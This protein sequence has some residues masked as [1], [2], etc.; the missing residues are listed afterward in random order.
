MPIA[1]GYLA[2]AFTLGITAKNAGMTA[3]Q[4]TITSLAC[5]ASAGQ[6]AG[7][8]VI[9]AGGTY[10]EMA[11]MELVAN[12]RYLLMSCSLSQKFS[13]KT[14]LIHRLAVG[15][16]VTDEIFGVAVSEPGFLNPFYNYGMITVAVPGWALGTFLGV[17]L[18]NILPAPV[19]SAL[20][21]GLYGMFIAIIIPPAK[22]SRILTVLITISMAASFLFSKLPATATISP[23]IRTI[24]LTVVIAGIAAVFFPVKE[25]ADR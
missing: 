19:V 12:L 24:I 3:W 8:T 14:G 13:P 4:A 9:A 20:S 16:A 21:V 5:N 1:L 23:G 7:F 17:T 11:I 6:Y 25:E 10:I 2:V 15:Y 18:G 22:K